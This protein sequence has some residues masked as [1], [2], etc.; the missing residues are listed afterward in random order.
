[1]HLSVS[2]AADKVREDTTLIGTRGASPSPKMPFLD[3]MKGAKGDELAV[4]VHGSRVQSKGIHSQKRGLRNTTSKHSA[5]NIS[6]FQ[7]S[8][9]LNKKILCIIVNIMHH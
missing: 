4:R 6:T 9:F 8:Q 7:I 2:N 5:L 1:M 3:E